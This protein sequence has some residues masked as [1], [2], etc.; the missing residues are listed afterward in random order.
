MTPFSWEFK[1]ENVSEIMDSG[2]RRSNT[3]YLILCY[4]YSDTETTEGSRRK[5]CQH[6]DGMVEHFLAGWL[7]LA[8]KEYIK[9]HE[10]GVYTTTVRY[11]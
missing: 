9:R 8:K 7:T 2:C 1:G 4:K 10:K 11:L 3:E 5:M 6:F